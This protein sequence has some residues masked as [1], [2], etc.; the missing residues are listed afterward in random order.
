MIRS[1]SLLVFVGSYKLVVYS[2]KDDSWFGPLAISPTDYAISTRSGI[3]LGKATGL[4]YIK[5]SDIIA[6][7]KKSGRALTT[8]QYLARRNRFI[9]AA[10]PLDQAKFAIG[11]GQFAK[12]AKLL[13]SILKREPDHSEATTLK[14]YLPVR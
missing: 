9:A 1:G 3:W 13:D 4:S 10:K 11:L 5:T 6:V 2:P 7:A 14:A 8:K 12:A